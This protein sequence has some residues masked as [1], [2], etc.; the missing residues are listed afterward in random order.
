MLLEGQGLE[1]IIFAC[2]Q[3][4]SELVKKD[5]HELG[6]RKITV[7]AVAP[8]LIKTRMTAPMSREMLNSALSHTPLGELGTP[9]DVANAVLFLASKNARY[10][11]GAVI[12]VSGGMNL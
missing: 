12:P 10:I 6:K 3:Y 1:R 11:T 4:K 7:N 9:E 2:A 8:G 5:F